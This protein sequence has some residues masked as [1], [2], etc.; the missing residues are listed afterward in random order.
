MNRP[1]DPR[2]AAAMEKLKCSG[3]ICPTLA[4]EMETERI[5]T[6]MLVEEIAHGLNLTWRTVGAL[7]ELR[8][9]GRIQL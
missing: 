2:I 8:P 1:T 5:L 6:E 7:R 4:A 9:G 3:W